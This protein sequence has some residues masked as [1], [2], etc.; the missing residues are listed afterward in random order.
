MSLK[1]GKE[2]FYPV[3]PSEKMT[4]IVAIEHSILKWTGLSKAI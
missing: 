3:A 2:E 4:K 1:T